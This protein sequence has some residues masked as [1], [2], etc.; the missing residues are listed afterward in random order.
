MP[1]SSVFGWLRM[2]ARR[3]PVRST[4]GI[5]FAPRL[6]A[7]ESQTRSSTVMVTSAADS[8]PVSLRAALAAAH[9]GDHIAFANPVH[10]I[11]LAGESDG[12]AG[13]DPEEVPGRESLGWVGLAPPAAP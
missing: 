3:R 4:P 5:R 6:E 10:S 2:P 11:T 1:R 7:M 8:G 9:A 12:A 13:A